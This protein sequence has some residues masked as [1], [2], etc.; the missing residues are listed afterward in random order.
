[1][2]RAHGH[3]AW[4]HRR[5]FDDT[6]HTCYCSL[7]PSAST[8]GDALARRLLYGRVTS[9]SSSTTS[10][11]MATG[12]RR[13]GLVMPA[14]SQDRRLTRPPPFPR[15]NNSEWD[16]TFNTHDA[17][18]SPGWT[19]RGASR[20]M[21]L[22]Q[23]PWHGLIP[24]RVTSRVTKLIVGLRTFGFAAKNQ[25]DIKAGLCQIHLAYPGQHCP[26]HSSDL[27]S[28]GSTAP[29][30]RYRR[31][32]PHFQ[33]QLYSAT[34]SSP[35]SRCATSQRIITSTRPAQTQAPTSAAPR[36]TATAISH[37]RQ[38]L[39]NATLFF[40]KPARYVANEPPRLKSPWSADH[41]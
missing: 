40:L 25:V 20:P 9:H 5:L 41:G 10:W 1:M 15:P 28:I 14:A 37:V 32:L 18:P 36:Q 19:R 17:H 30:G 29:G 12:A 34:T 39:M 22:R 27:A 13:R 35:S 24:R 33:P 26:P 16:G 21:L 31:H 38:G 7:A 11:P 4:C 2:R 3:A 23:Q 6:R 8:P